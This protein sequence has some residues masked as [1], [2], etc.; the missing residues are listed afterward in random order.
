M[1]GEIKL[2]SVILVLSFGISALALYL[3]GIPWFIPQFYALSMSD[4]INPCTFVIYTMLLIALS[5]RKVEKKQLY[6]VGSAFI[7]AVYI[8]YYLLGVGLLYL[9]QYIPLWF[10]GFL[11]IAFGVYTIVTGIMEKSRIADKKGIRKKMFSTEATFMSSFFLGV[12]VS[13]TL[14]PCS[15]GSY[16]VYATI[17]SHGSRAL[18]FLLLALYNVI[19]VL[20]LVLILLTM[21]SISESKRFSQALVRHSRELSVVAGILLIGIGVWVLMGGSV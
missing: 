17:I 1:R 9:G 13:T 12:V 21:G 18:A 11:A 20:P 5:V 2:L 8:S 6:I 4:S 7:L 3:L 16:L 10:A 14:L 19:F 15:A